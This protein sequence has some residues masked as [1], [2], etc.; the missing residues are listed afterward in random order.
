ME[1][2]SQNKHHVVL[3]Y[4]RQNEKLITIE[5]L[6]KNNRRSINYVKSDSIFYESK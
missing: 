5:N 6:H 3:E 2:N 1:S 4:I